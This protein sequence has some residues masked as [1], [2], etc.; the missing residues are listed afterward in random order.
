MNVRIVEVGPRDGLQN[1]KRFLSTYAK[2]TLIQKLVASG[3]REIEATSF[4]HPKWIPQLADADE[5]VAELP[6]DSDVNYRVLVPNAKGLE[7]V[8]HS[9]LK[10][11]AIFCSASE[12]HNQKN[13]NRMREESLADFMKFVPVALEQGLRV[14]AYL[15]TVF[16]CPYE[17]EISLDQVHE[18]SERLFDFGVYEISLGDTT[19]VATPAS[20]K[21][22]L[23]SLLSQ[24]PAEKLAVHFHD[25]KGMG[26]AN[27]Y[28]AFEMGIQ[29]FDSSIG[30]LG[31]CPYAPGA[32]G[33][34]ATEDLIYLLQGS[35]IDT[36][37]DL[38]QLCRTS[39]WLEG[40]LG[41]KLPSKVLRAHLA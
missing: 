40:Q 1:E 2:K 14:R 32:S 25:T 7:R 39:Q 38:D 23:G 36:G 6:A 30:G 33:N 11:I 41:K 26:V 10:E 34:L 17:G 8:N 5:L 13:V 4:V 31:G 15:S 19:G 28:K 9:I 24:F 27:A 12:T 21:R 16:G 37:V 29:T 22:V 20:V 35:G 3:L 18:M